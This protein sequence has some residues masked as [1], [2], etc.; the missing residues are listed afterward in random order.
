MKHRL[1]WLIIISILNSVSLGLLA[2]SA[3]ERIYNFHYSSTGYD[4]IST[5][6]GNF[7]ITGKVT[8]EV[9]NNTWDRNAFLLKVNNV[10]DT[11]WFKEYTITEYQYG[12]LTI[13][14]SS[15]DF[16]IIGNTHIVG[17]P[18]E[19]LA[20]KVDSVGNFIWKEVYNEICS[21]TAVSIIE[22]DSGNYIIA[23]ETCTVE[24]G[25]NDLYLI[26]IN[27]SGGLIWE[28][29]I[30]QS[31]QAYA[32]SMIELIDGNCLIVGSTYNFISDLHKIYIVKI[33]NNGDTLWTNCIDSCFDCGGISAVESKDGDYIITSY[34]D[35][36]EIHK[37]N[38]D[39]ILIWSKRLPKRYYDPYIVKSKNGQYQVLA[40]RDRPRGYVQCILSFDESGELTNEE[41]LHSFDLENYQK[42]NSFIESDNNMIFTGYTRIDGRPRTVF[43]KY[44]LIYIDGLKNDSLFCGETYQFN[45]RIVYFGP[46]EDVSYSWVDEKLRDTANLKP[47][48]NIYE[49]HL[50][51][52]SAYASDFVAIDSAQITVEPLKIDV[53]NDT[54]II[55]GDT[56]QLYCSVNSSSP[57]IINNWSPE[58]SLDNP[59]TLTPRAF[60]TEPSL[61]LLRASDSICSASDSLQ[62]D[63]LPANFN[64]GFSADKQLLTAPPFAFQFTNNTENREL[65]NFIWYFGDRDSLASNNEMVFHEYEFNGLYDIALCATHKATGCQDTVL[66]SEY[67]YCTGGNDPVT[68]IEFSERNEEFIFSY[69][70]FNQIIEITLNNSKIIPYKILIMDVS[71]RIINDILNNSSLISKISLSSFPEGVYL[72]TIMSKNHLT[73]RKIIK[74]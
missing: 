32:N 27:D 35:S 43:G 47:T 17:E 3:S 30:N 22:V 7:V 45:P 52:F 20:I 62:I 36:L 59:N 42:G 44:P 49:S 40:N 65:Y 61:Y 11:L 73:T 71:G 8:K 64:L 51:K 39:G 13:E 9:A 69:D 23:G 26:K 41:I 29:K 34:S 57:R 14:T 12:Y 16:L 60:P 74:L 15:G 66:K 5:S 46:Q 68:N 4:I 6:D 2:Q 37:V 31:D 58:K 54:S 55:C 24:T 19:M 18:S 67:I 38:P 56:I 28:K 21:S 72:I 63:I 1:A 10:G 53:G 48:I 50:Y 25:F 33:D 70:S